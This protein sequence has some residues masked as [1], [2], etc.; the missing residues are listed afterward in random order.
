MLPSSCRMAWPFLVRLP[1]PEMTPEMFIWV[2]PL[3]P[4]TLTMP[5]AAPSAMALSRV[6]PVALLVR[7]PP[8]S[9]RV[10]EERKSSL[11][12][13]RV[14]AVTLMPPDMLASLLELVSARVPPP[15]LASEPLPARVLPRDMVPLA[16]LKSSV[17]PPPRV[18]VLPLKVRPAAESP[19][20][21]R[22]SLTDRLPARLTD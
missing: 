4:P 3:P 6:K 19:L 20:R 9:V 1:V 7:V 17:V 10:P 12:I 21:V 5:P 14:P 11:E 15:A 8:F 13:C 18:M 22:L 16:L 2:A